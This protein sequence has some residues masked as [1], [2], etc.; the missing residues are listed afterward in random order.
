MILASFWAKLANLIAAN[1]SG[2]IYSTFLFVFLCSIV[3]CSFSSLFAVAI[4]AF[5][6]PKLPS[7]CSKLFP[8]G[9]SSYTLETHFKAC[10]MH[11][12]PFF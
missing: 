4:S 5:S 7:F 8:H 1:I 12:H 11:M 3:T 10:I 6:R 2:N 9:P